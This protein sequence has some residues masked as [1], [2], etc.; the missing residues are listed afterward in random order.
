[1][2]LEGVEG[3]ASRPGRSL[4]PGKARYPLYRRLG[5]PRASLDR[6]GKSRHP[7]GFF[8]LWLTF[9]GTFHFYCTI[10]SQLHWNRPYMAYINNTWQHC[11]WDYKQWRTWRDPHPFHI[12]LVLLQRCELRIPVN[13]P[14]TK[15]QHYCSFTCYHELLSTFGSLFTSVRDSLHRLCSMFYRLGN[16][17]LLPRESVVIQHVTISLIN[18]C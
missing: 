10:H 13:S 11:S 3:S 18:A 14:G 15:H 7:P 16:S 6:C 8:F 12:V 1:M 2:A 17:L 4:P 9:I 5:G